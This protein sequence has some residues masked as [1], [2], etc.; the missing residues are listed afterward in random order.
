MVW[1]Q[2][3]SWCGLRWGLWDLRCPN[4]L[5]SV[6]AAGMVWD[7]FSCRYGLRSARGAAGMG[8]DLWAVDII[9]G[10]SS[11]RYGIRSGQ[12]PIWFGA[13]AAA[14]RVRGLRSC[15]NGLT[16]E[17]LPI[18]FEVW[19]AAYMVWGLSSCRYGLRS[20]A[21]APA[22]KPERDLWLLWPPLLH[23]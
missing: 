1:G 5:M 20:W 15:W 17:Q 8:W 19:A 11:C 21:A 13:W 18:W 4:G 12:L 7:L 10:Q 14:C 9:W 2:S 6:A 16:S 22:G 3:N 23:P